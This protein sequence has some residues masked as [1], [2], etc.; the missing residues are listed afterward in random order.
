MAE[1][2]L[3]NYAGN[4]VDVYSAGLELREI[5]P[6]TY[7]VMA[8]MDIDMRG[9]RNKPLWQ[10]YVGYHFRTII[11]L[12]DNGEGY[13]P[14]NLGISDETVRWY[15]KNPLTQPVAAS[16]LLKQFRLVR[17]SIDLMVRS[18][19]ENNRFPVA[20]FG[21]PWLAMDETQPLETGMDYIQL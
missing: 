17:D 2:M 14:D 15:V 11:N 7:Q 8:E 3:R 6:Y 4:S 1:A 12:C 10:Y 13:V 21:Y 16:D 20:P 18:W 9:Q 5:H 19:I